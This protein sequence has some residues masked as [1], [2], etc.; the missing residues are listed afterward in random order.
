MKL[1]KKS[2]I[3]LIIA[4]YAIILF[5]NPGNYF[6]LSIIDS[7]R[8]ALVV[9]IP[10]IFCLFVF[11]DNIRNLKV[12][13]KN[14]VP[15]I[16]YCL[17][18]IWL[19]LTFL[20][21]IKVGIE[22]LKGLI[23]FGVLLTFTLFLFNIEYEDNKKAEIKKHLFIA[24]AISAVLGIVQYVFQIDLN[25]YNNAKY[26]G[27]LGRINSTFF[28][29]TL[30]DKF[31]V[32]MFGIVSY[33]LLNDKDNKWYKLLLI[34]CMLGVTLTFSRSGQLIFLAMSFIFFIASLIK[35]H[36]KNSLLM[37]LLV[38]VMIL[39]PG[40]KYSV[41]SAFDHVYETVHMPKVLQINFVKL[42]G[43][44]K[45]EI[46]GSNSSGVSSEQLVD[47]DFVGDEEGSKFFRDYYKNVGMTLLKE[48]PVFGIGV[49]NYYYL[50]INQ[51]AKDYL[52]NDS[53]ISDEYPY[54]YPHSGY[55]QVLAETGYVGLILLFSF[56][57]SLAIGKFYQ[58]E[59]KLELYAILMLIFAFCISNI[60][61]CLFHSKQYIY[62]L[63]I[64]YTLYCN[65]SAKEHKKTKKKLNK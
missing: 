25:T 6:S 1:T 65:L 41:Q 31:V 37:V 11:F 29:A 40:A 60:T 20:F 58:K 18:I 44:R 62:T 42:L 46:S 56:F 45:E 4:I 17:T 23:H 24:F 21:G 59:N 16:I 52:T 26:P 28:I 63:I 53:V 43:D 10:G 27:I 36:Y 61:E 54:M 2:E 50:Y 57:L 13:L 48:Y 35:K 30:F 5:L 9:I 32:V 14:K 34:L 15:F 64:I 7:I 3:L 47:K 22:S 33:E 39:I 8:R 19:F 12:L 51:N 38:I 49:G 55:V